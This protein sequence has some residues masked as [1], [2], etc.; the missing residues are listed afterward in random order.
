MLCL[1]DKHEHVTKNVK[2]EHVTKNV[3]IRIKY[4]YKVAKT[5]EFSHNL[6]D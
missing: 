5:Y 4:L 2:H 3:K 6:K 1:N